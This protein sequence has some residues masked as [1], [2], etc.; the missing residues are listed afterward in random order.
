MLCACTM[1]AFLL[2]AYVTAKGYRD[3]TTANKTLGPGVGF[4]VNKP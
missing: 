3:F 2:V 4:W 1:N